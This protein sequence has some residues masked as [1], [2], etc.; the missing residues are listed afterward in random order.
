L[1]HAEAL[2]AEPFRSKHIGYEEAKDLIWR[3]YSDFCKWGDATPLNEA[4][5]EGRLVAEHYD[6]K[7]KWL[8]LPAEW[9]NDPSIIFSGIPSPG[10]TL[11]KHLRFL[12]SEFDELW[13]EP[14]G[15]SAERDPPHPSSMR[16]EG[17]NPG[18][19]PRKWDW[20]GALI[21]M[22]RVAELD[23]LLQ[24]P[25]TQAR[26]AKLLSDWFVMTA[27]DHPPESQIR[28]YA[29]RIARAVGAEN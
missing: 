23:G 4:C 22:I 25:G 21:E 1:H 11:S 16:N 5:R 24:G 29:S 27:G 26:I 7:G 2:V 9:W 19:R 14:K 20:D 28:E 10:D 12:R 6:S 13:P 15:D 17:K 18:G 3:R 8:S